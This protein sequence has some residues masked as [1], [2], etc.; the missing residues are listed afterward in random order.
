M[1]PGRLEQ[2]LGLGVLEPV[3]RPAPEHER[4]RSLTEPLFYSPALAKALS[5][6]SSAVI[7]GVSG[8]G[9]AA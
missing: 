2:R 8:L 3:V 5:L 7:I 1:V 6:I 9:G 4:D